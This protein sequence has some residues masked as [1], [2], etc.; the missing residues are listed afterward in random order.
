MITLSNSD[1]ILR[2]SSTT[3]SRPLMSSSAATAVFAI[4]VN[5]INPLSIQTVR[6]NIAEN[7]V[8]EQI[9]GA[10]AGVHRG[11]HEGRRDVEAG[12]R[13]R[14][15]SARRR[16]VHRQRLLHVPCRVFV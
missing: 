13:D 4:L 1:V 11:A 7:R 3:M 16:K 10:R 15:N 5:V 6:L 8:G 12:H 9:T 2:T 14:R